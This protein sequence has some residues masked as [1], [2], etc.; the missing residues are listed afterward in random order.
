MSTASPACA[1]HGFSNIAGPA[2]RAGRDRG[3]ERP[4]LR[5]DASR[6]CT[7]V[8]KFSIVA[9]IATPVCGETS[10]RLPAFS[11]FL[12]GSCPNYRD[13]RNK[14]RQIGRQPPNR[15]ESLAC[16][17]REHAVFNVSLVVIRLVAAEVIGVEPSFIVMVYA[18]AAGISR[19]CNDDPLL[20]VNF[21][22]C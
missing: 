11:L 3:A 10:S 12:P 19:I 7:F 21:A 15:F 22:F 16:D 8:S 18:A 14:R 9:S 6:I 13:R 17:I 5:L 4:Q 1:A 20:R 2:R